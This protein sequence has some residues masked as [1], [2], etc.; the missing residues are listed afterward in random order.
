MLRL[1]VYSFPRA[2]TPWAGA[3][4]AS[5]AFPAPGRHGL[6]LRMRVPRRVRPH[7]LRLRGGRLCRPARKG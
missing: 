2:G 5:I 1:L 3:A 6:L 4:R 7:G